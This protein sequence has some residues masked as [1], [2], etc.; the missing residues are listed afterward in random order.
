MART[1]TSP[2]WADALWSPRPI[3]SERSRSPTPDSVT[4]VC[5]AD[6]LRSTVK[7]PLTTSYP[8]GTRTRA[9]MAPAA[10]LPMSPKPDE[11]GIGV[12]PRRQPEGEP[13]AELADVRVPGE[14]RDR[15]LGERAAVRR[16]CTRRPVREPHP[17]DDLPGRL[18]RHRHRHERAV[19]IGSRRLPADRDVLQLEARVQRGKPR[20]HPELQVTVLGARHLDAHAAVD[21]A[22]R[23][24]DRRARARTGARRR[25]KRFAGTARPPGDSDGDAGSSVGI[26]GSAGSAEVFAGSA[27]AVETGVIARKT[28]AATTTHAPRRRQS[29]PI[30]RVSQT[31]ALRERQEVCASGPAARALSTWTSASRSCVDPV[32]LVLARRAARTTRARRCGCGRRR[33]RRACRAPPR[34]CIRSRVITGTLRS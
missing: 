3:A 25:A 20:E 13:V 5:P 11:R 32:A 17:D 15:R 30:G 24:I 26:A 6:S 21:L 31:C 8:V 34:S 18:R 28:A 19:P 23:G 9:V 22:R 16:P 12:G 10:K 29:R 33:R 27:P 14:E 2:D 7:P 4:V 1:V